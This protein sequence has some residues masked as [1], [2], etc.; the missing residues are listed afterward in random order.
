MWNHKTI[1]VPVLVRAMGMIKK[2]TDKH[3]NKTP[4]S[5]WL[6]DIQQMRFAEQPISLG[7]IS[8]KRGS[9]KHK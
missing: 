9:K 5:P 7:K 3:I 1:N 6:Y 2:G 4:G 8:P